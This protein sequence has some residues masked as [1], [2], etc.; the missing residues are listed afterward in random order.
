MSK[1]QKVPKSVFVVRMYTF[2]HFLI[3]EIL[4]NHRNIFLSVKMVKVV[5]LFIL[6][7]TTEVVGQ[8]TVTSLAFVASV[9]SLGI[10]EPL[11]TLMGSASVIFPMAAFIVKEMKTQRGY[12]VDPFN[13]V[14]ILKYPKYIKYILIN[15]LIYL[16]YLKYRE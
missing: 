10:T 4:L 6:K 5:C 15:L 12:E 8:G 2:K 14:L 3:F 1:T 11:N 9:Y 13:S 16:K 7:L